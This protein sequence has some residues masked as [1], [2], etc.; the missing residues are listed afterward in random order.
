MILRFQ[1]IDN[2]LQVLTAYGGTDNSR[3]PL[4]IPGAGTEQWHLG[5][6]APLS[7]DFC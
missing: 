3:T 4:L 7:E 2:T 5:G 6:S 1:F